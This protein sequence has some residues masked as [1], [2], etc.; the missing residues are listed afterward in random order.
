DV[1]QE[2]GAR[3]EDAHPAFG[4]RRVGVQQV[5]GAVQGDGGLAGARPALDHQRPL[6]GGADHGVLLGLERGHH[7]PH[8]PGA[9]GGECLHQGGLTYEGRVCAVEIEQFV[10]DPHHGAAPG[11]QVT[12]PA[13]IGP[14][15]GG[16]GVEVRGGRGTP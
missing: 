5:G 12:P 3:A 4:D 2:G 11:A 14:A 1:V 6:H 10:V 13:H 7:V 16:G 15:G 8:A 9:A